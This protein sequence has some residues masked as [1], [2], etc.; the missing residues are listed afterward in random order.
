MGQYTLAWGGGNRPPRRNG[1]IDPHILV[2]AALCGIEDV[3][4]VGGAQAIAAM[5]YGTETVPKVDKIFGPGNAWVT[6]AKIMV[7]QDP[8][9]AAIDMPAGPSELLVIADR[10]ANPAFVAADLL[11]QAEHGRD[12]QVIFIT[13]DEQVMAQVLQSLHV[14]LEKL[15]RKEIALASLCYARFIITASL[16]EA[17]DISN[18]YAPEHLILNIKDIE[19]SLKDRI[20]NAGSVFLGPWSPEAVGDYASGTNHV[21]PTYGYARSMGGISLES[22]LKPITFQEL[23]PEGLKEIGPTVETLAGI[24]GLDA[25]KNAVTIRLQ[26]LGEREYER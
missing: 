10:F 14:Q 9:G 26:S 18:R 12:S 7:S 6:E 1:T 2:A 20:R 8:A 22:F 19:S 4:K 15:P 25:H 16:D 3:Y 24:E 21:L 11:S 23:T 13:T 5:A 17:I